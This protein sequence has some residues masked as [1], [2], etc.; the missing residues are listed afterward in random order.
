MLALDLQFST[1]T[2]RVQSAPTGE[3]RQVSIQLIVSVSHSVNVSL[4]YKTKTYSSMR[5]MMLCWLSRTTGAE[6]N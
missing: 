5:D 6:G 1:F 4:R 2:T 3:L